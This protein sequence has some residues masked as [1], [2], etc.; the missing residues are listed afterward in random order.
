MIIINVYTDAMCHC[1]KSLLK[2][3]QETQYVSDDNNISYH[4]CAIMIN[5]L[6]N[7][8]ITNI[9]SDNNNIHT[10]YIISK[11]IKFSK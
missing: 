1:F 5:A 3:Y 6:V 2:K 8:K 10:I 9:E 4:N 7:Y 11:N